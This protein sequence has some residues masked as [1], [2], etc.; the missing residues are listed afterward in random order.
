MLDL[1]RLQRLRLSGRPFG[2]RVVASLYLRPNYF[3]NKVRIRFENDERL[4]P[5]PVIFAMNHTDAFNYWPFQTALWL[6]R[7]RLTAT[8]VKGK[9]YEGRVMAAFMALT[10]NIPTVSRGYLLTKDYVQTM[11]ERPTNEA[12]QQLRACIGQVAASEAG[13]AASDTPVDLGAVPA[14]VLER[15]RNILGYD[16]NPAQES[17]AQAI[18]GLFRQMMHRFVELNGECFSKG[19]D[20]LVFPQ[21]TRSLRLLPGRIGL[22]QVALHFR[23][24]VVPVGCN[25]SDLIYP[26]TSSWAQ[27]GEVTYRFGEPLTYDQAVDFHIDGPFDPFTAEAEARHGEQF[28]GYVDLVTRRIN[29]LLD[30]RYQLDASATSGGERGSERFV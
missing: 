7:D 8:W 25:G 21:G 26:G 10:N 29:G 14:A 15:P 1:K 13:E 4:V 9:F 19:C 28:Q 22:A 17:Y 6:E 23:R 30:E 3:L 5:E 11:G 12:Y 16:F 2:Q 24:T 27:E 18:N 20:L